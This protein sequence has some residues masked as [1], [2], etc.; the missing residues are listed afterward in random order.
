MCRLK[1][2]HI[3]RMQY[4]IFAL[5]YQSEVSICKDIQEVVFEDWMFE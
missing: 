1:S 5:H 4:D 3:N 2:E